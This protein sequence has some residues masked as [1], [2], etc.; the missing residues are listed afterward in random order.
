MNIILEV[1][2]CVR[3]IKPMIRFSESGYG[4]SGSFKGGNGRY[5]QCRAWL[6]LVDLQEGFL[7][8][9]LM[10][11]RCEKRAKW[12]L[13]ACMSSEVGARNCS[14]KWF[15]FGYKKHTVTGCNDIPLGV[16]HYVKYILFKAQWSLY[17]P[18][19]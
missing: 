12:Q 13:I 11:L 3:W 19:V 2:D 10:P 4:I 15:L 17:V 7:C 6:Q 1:W 9:C 18:P 14:L 16:R 5:F 8:S